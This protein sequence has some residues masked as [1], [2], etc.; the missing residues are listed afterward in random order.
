[1]MKGI[2]LAVVMCCLGCSAVKS[3]TPQ[4]GATAIGDLLK[5][6]DYSTLFQ[7]R[8]SEWH[9]VEAQGANPE[10]AIKKLSAAWEKNHDMLVKLFEQLTTAEYTLSKNDMPQKTETGDVATA[11]VSLGEKKIPYR[12]YKMKNGLW[13]FHM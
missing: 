9:K 12:L 7:Q 6:R 2:L 8:Y 10:V 11:N 1:M 13:G 4:E 3:E 5:K